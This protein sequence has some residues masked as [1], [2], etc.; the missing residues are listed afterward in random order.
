MIQNKLIAIHESFYCPPTAINQANLPLKDLSTESIWDR[1][2]VKQSCPIK[3]ISK[4]KGEF[5]VS[6]ELASRDPEPSDLV[7][8]CKSW[9]IFVIGGMAMVLHGFRKISR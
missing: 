9:T 3:K 6:E 7:K 5:I 2:I 8:I 1:L 4:S